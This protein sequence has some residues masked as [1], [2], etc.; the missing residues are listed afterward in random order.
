MKKGVLL[1]LI[2][3]LILILLSAG[4]A[5]AQGGQEDGAVR[6]LKGLIAGSQGEEKALLVKRLGDLYAERGDAA[7][8][9]A[10]YEEA[11]R[12]K[13]D[14][15]FSERFEMGRWM[16]WGGMHAEAIEIFNGLLKEDPENR[17]VRL[18][19]ARTLGWKGDLE[20]ASEESKVLM[21]RYSED[22]DVLLLNA[23]ISRWR[24]DQESAIILYK[25]VLLEEPGNF[26]AKLGIAYAYLWKGD[27]LLSSRFAKELRLLSPED[28]EVS[29]LIGS[30][31]ERTQSSLEAGS[32]Y[33]EDTDDNRLKTYSIGYKWTPLSAIQYV[34]RI[35][36][37]YKHLSASDQALSNSAD[38][39]GLSIG[40][41]LGNIGELNLGGTL[42]SLNRDERD[43]VSHG[44]WSLGVRRNVPTG[45]INVSAVKSILTD[46]A[47]LIE[48]DIRVYAFAIGGQ[49]TLRE[50]FVLQGNYIYRDYSD[51]NRADDLTISPGII[52][53]KAPLQVQLGYRFRWLD[54]EE[55]TGGGYFD[56]SDFQ[57]HQLVLTLYGEKG[58][59]Y[60][61]LE[62]FGGRQFFE[63]NDVSS[64]DDIFGASGSMGYRISRRVLAEI[65][66]EAGNYALQSAAG[67]RMWMVGGRIKLS[68]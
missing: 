17:E 39:I 52:V 19:L 41:G 31:R 30:I 53:K 21:D 64:S 10:Q 3:I 20:A 43:S 12:L 35:R 14:F 1:S 46:T 26:D 13:R 45:N 49:K 40:R 66:G 42:V 5:L 47:T 50:R 65:N 6:E 9:A 18:S 28:K 15:P 37:E 57:S 7:S 4:F 11:L 56:P 55:Q 32:S 48:N 29:D 8:A 44:T 23:D 2:L 60:G 51:E 25:K 33:Y 61:F 34:K 67:F 27:I 58:G 22:L 54:F 16:G 59:F 62:S 68:I 24:G 63:R 38:L 36:L